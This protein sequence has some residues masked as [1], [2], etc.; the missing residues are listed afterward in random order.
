MTSQVDLIESIIAPSLRFRISF[1]SKACSQQLAFRH[2]ANHFFHAQNHFH[3]INFTFSLLITP[4][5]AAAV[6][7]AAVVV[8]AAKGDK[9]VGGGWRKGGGVGGGW[10]EGGGVGGGWRE[11]GGVGGGW[12]EGGG[13]GGGWKKD[14]GSE[15]AQQQ[16]HQHNAVHC[17]G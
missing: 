14:G 11:G 7:A 1:H 8:V 17:I 9:G 4:T 6:A 15:S 12:R 16:T 3:V 10:K 5:F 13:V 2:E